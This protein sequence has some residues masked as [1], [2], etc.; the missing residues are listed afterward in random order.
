MFPRSFQKAI[1]GP[2]AQQRRTRISVLLVGSKH[3]VPSCCM[4]VHTGRRGPIPKLLCVK[5]FMYGV[6]GKDVQ[7]VLRAASVSRSAPTPLPPSLMVPSDRGLA[8]SSIVIW[9]V[10]VSLV[11]R[12]SPEQSSRVP[13]HIHPCGTQ[14]GSGLA[15]KARAQHWPISAIGSALSN[16]E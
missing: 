12:K 11:A 1:S 5:W 13:A 16:V 8:T 10:P 15:E 2:P 4:N 14:G 6:L 9:Q 7:R 3:E